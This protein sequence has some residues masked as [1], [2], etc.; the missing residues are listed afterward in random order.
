MGKLPPFPAPLSCS[1]FSN[2]RGDKRSFLLLF[3]APVTHPRLPFPGI[4]LS[5]HP[6]LSLPRSPLSPCPHR[7]PNHLLDQEEGWEGLSIR[8]KLPRTLGEKDGSSS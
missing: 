7:C 6:A 2:T 3:D 5:F 1:S 4:A 8:I